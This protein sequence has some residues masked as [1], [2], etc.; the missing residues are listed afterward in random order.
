ML[1]CI[2]CGDSGEMHYLDV[3]T[4]CAVKKS[5]VSARNFGHRECNP[6]RYTE[7]DKWEEISAC[8]MLAL[9]VISLFAF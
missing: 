9:M 4:Q 7:L 5:I 2:Y 6:S 3:C 1:S 8:M